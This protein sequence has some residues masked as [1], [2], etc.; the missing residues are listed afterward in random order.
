MAAK[1]LKAVVEAT[2][3]EIRNPLLA[4]ALSVAQSLANCS[5][6]ANKI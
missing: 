3:G 2:L 4:L 5:G 6:L 1:H